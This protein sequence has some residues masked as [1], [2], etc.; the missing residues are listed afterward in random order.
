MAVEEDEETRDYWVISVLI[1]LVIF[2][3]LALA[4]YYSHWHWLPSLWFGYTWPSLKGNGPEA[5]VQTIVYGAV[6][7]ILIPPVRKFIKREFDK[8]HKTIKD[9]HDELH[10][11]MHHLADKLGVERFERQ[12]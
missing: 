3:V 11:H 12:K 5:L 6:A 9:G 8:V 7:I 4:S 2:F 1:C 10:D